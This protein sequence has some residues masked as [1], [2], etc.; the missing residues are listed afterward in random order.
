MLPISRILIPKR[1]DFQEHFLKLIKMSFIKKTL[2]IIKL[3]L[4]QNILLN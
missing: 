1:N 2:K 4:K 3:H